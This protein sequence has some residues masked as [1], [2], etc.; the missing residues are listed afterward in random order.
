MAAG[1]PGQADVPEIDVQQA[2]QYIAE[3]SSD[4]A[5]VLLDVRTPA[6]V[7]EAHIAGCVMLDLNGG[8]FLRQL[9][10]LDPQKDYLLVCRSGN[11]SGYA[12]AVMLNLGFRRAVNMQ[13]GMLD[14]IRAGYDV[15][16]G[17]VESA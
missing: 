10:R 7:A 13:G 4:S 17:G 2:R 6:E 5:F 1:M 3:K 16:S 15:E 14:W 11:R 9:P 12:A 8:E